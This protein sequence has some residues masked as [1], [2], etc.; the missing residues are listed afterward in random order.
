MLHAY[1][2]G[3]VAATRDTHAGFHRLAPTN[4][5]TVVEKRRQSCDCK[6][7]HRCSVSM[8]KVTPTEAI[9]SEA[10][11]LGTE[12]V[13]PPTNADLTSVS[14][15]QSA[16]V[17]TEFNTDS[18]WRHLNHLKFLDSLQILT[19][20]SS[21]NPNS[22]DG[23]SS[24]ANRTTPTEDSVWSKGGARFTN[25]RNSEYF[26]PCQEAADRSLRCLRRNGGD[27]EMCS[28]FFE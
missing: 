21:A 7:L 25:K 4:R 10:E 16:T 9:E 5:G 3:A 8:D 12:L 24:D 20:M 6:R 15:C 19:E 27:R 22:R 14:S 2:V 11:K 23:Q 17:Y 26:D 28:D 18:T 13:P 1:L